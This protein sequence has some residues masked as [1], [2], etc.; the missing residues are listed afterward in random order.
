MRVRGALG[1]IVIDNKLWIG[2]TTCLC[3]IAA[4][5]NKNMLIVPA[6]GLLVLATFA[7][8]RRDV[9][10]RIS[11]FLI[12]IAAFTG[13][14]YLS[15]LWATDSALTIPKGNAMFFIFVFMI[16]VTVANTDDGAVERMLKCLM[17]GGYAVA[18]LYVAQN[19][20][21]GVS[22]AVE[23]MGRVS[24]EV[25]NAN[26]L[27]MVT[28]YAVIINLYFI[29]CINKKLKA[30]DILILPALMII[31]LSGSRKALLIVALGL[32]GILLV[33]N[34][35]RKRSDISAL[36]W[37]IVLFI[38]LAAVIALFT[39]PALSGQAKRITDVFEAFSG[40]G[41][42]GENSAWLRARYVE[43]G[44][45]LFRMNPLGGV[46]IG[47]ANHYTLA[48]YGKDHYLHN[49]IFEMLGCGGIIGFALYYS[50]YVYL[51]AVFIKY[52]KYGT[53]EYPFCFILLIIWLIM[54]FGMV[55]YFSK[56][57]YF[58][59]LLFWLEAE[60]LKRNAKETSYENVSIC[61]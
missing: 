38:A 43:L 6:V 5:F 9:S 1:N 10:I 54:D 37:M 23:E 44:M 14:V 11:S 30:L 51:I 19:G 22:Q 26:S 3:F 58:Y 21:S 7:V 39:I 33:N 29:F 28:A 55:K 18:V 12:Y 17:Y 31:Y 4:V 15:S 41:T 48:L 47:N 50:I 59:L 40:G 25:L 16:L 60:R 24:N 57:T 20:I 49:N 45:D 27:G 35:K 46:G 56:S 32:L 36:K 2:I 8:Y 34:L 61:G 53:K 52:R 42:R 13:Y